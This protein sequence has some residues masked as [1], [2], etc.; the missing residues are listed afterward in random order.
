L[1]SYKCEESSANS[2]VFETE[3]YN[4]DPY[5]SISG[6]IQQKEL[7]LK[8]FSVKSSINILILLKKFESDGN[9]SLVHNYQSSTITKAKGDIHVSE[10]SI[11]FWIGKYLVI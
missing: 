3:N 5:F 11:F 1:G 9:F 7:Y 6:E 2:N 8:L 4:W 10:T